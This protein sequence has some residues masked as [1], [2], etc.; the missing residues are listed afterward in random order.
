[1]PQ[2]SRVQNQPWMADVHSA[3]GGGGWG[4]G[5]TQKKQAAS[6]ANLLHGNLTDGVEQQERAHICYLFLFILTG[7]L[8]SPHL[9]TWN[10]LDG[11]W[12]VLSCAPFNIF[13]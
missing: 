10:N 1:M 12:F 4:H 6:A 5:A 9:S 2:S 7:D 3:F 13:C 11:L 8:V